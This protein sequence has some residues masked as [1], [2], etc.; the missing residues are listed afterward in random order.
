MRMQWPGAPGQS[1][2]ALRAR[3]AASFAASVIPMSIC[4][5]RRKSAKS[6]ARPESCCALVSVDS[7]AR[8]DFALVQGAGH[9]FKSEEALE[10]LAEF[11]SAHLLRAS[12]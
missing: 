11:L 7:A 12:K 10:E 5:H 4:F 9:G 6:R 1:H 3:H 8:V 2:V